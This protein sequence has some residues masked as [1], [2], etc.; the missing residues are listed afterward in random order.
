MPSI[1]ASCESAHAKALRADIKTENVLLYHSIAP[2]NAKDYDDPALPL[3][4]RIVDLGSATFENDWHQPLIGTNEYRAPEAILQLGWSY[5]VDVWGVGVIIAEIAMG[6]KPFG[7]QL[8][9]NVHLLLMERYLERE[10]PQDMLND[11]W[12]KGPAKMSRLLVQK[13]G[14]KVWINP[15][16]GD[17]LQERKYREAKVLRKAVSD[18][19]LLDLLQRLLVFEPA[20]RSA[21]GVLRNHP[22][23]AQA[24]FD[25]R[26]R[27]LS[28]RFILSCTLAFSVLLTFCAPRNQEC[29]QRM[30]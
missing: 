22:F 21:A 10:F 24:R 4:V 9:D 23:F 13:Q 18:S 5:E 11:A 14:Q 16:M 7:E 28:F 12:A 3:E 17:I 20:N 25:M 8:L 1:Q 2:S 15:K 29:T 6:I 30:R 27:G 19:Q 26:Y